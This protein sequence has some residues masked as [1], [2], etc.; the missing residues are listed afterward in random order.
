MEEILN[1]IIQYAPSIVS[2]IT[3]VATAFITIKK[4]V[5]SG[6][7]EISTLK[8]ENG[9]LRKDLQRSVSETQELRTELRKLA[10]KIDKIRE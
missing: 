9:S 2:I 3:M 5:A 10:N 4:I 1:N 7:D 8:Q 6:Q